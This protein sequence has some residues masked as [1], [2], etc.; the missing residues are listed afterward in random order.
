MSLTFVDYHSQGNANLGGTSLTTATFTTTA[1]NYLIAHVRPN[2]VTVS[3]IVDTAGHIT[4]SPVGTGP[5]GGRFYL[6]SVPSTDASNAIKVTFSGA[7]IF[8]GLAVWQFTPSGI[9][10]FDNEATALTPSGASVSSSSFNTNYLNEIVVA[11]FYPNALLTTWTQ[12]L[13]YTTDGLNSGTQTY[14]GSEHR[15]YSSQQTGLTATGTWSPG[16]TTGVM[17]TASF[18]FGLPFTGGVAISGME[19]LNRNITWL[20]QL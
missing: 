9:P 10:V 19:G 3:S 2:G 20:Q 8:Q 14:F 7:T 17:Y 15:I 16:S 4:F 5:D 13:G 6:A 12:G 1:G 18:G 11:V